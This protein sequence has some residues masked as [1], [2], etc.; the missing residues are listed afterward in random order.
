MSKITINSIERQ[1]VHSRI[2]LLYMKVSLVKQK[3]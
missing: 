2:Y 1:M 3:K